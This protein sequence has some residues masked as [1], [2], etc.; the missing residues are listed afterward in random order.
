[1]RM[2]RMIWVFFGRTCHTHSLIRVFADRMCLRQPPGYPKKDKREPIPYWVDVHVQIDLN[3]CWLHISYCTGSQKSEKWSSTHRYPSLPI[4]CS[5]TTLPTDRYGW[6][7]RLI[8]IWFFKQCS[9]FPKA[10]LINCICVVYICY[11]GLFPWPFV[12][13]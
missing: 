10:T 1:M 4:L 6:M 11:K 5:P 12:V 3:L 13:P 2:C 9:L 8:L 7:R